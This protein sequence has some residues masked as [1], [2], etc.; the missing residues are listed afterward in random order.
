[1][2]TYVTGESVGSGLY[3]SWRERDLRIVTEP[4][5]VLEG[6]PEGIYRRIP[7]WMLVVLAPVLGGL[8]AMAF[9]AII[10]SALLRVVAEQVGGFRVHT[11]GEEAEWGVYV[12]LNHL[13]VSHV[14]A[15]GE[16]LGGEVGT[17]FLRVPTW[18]LVVGSP[19][20]GGIY[21]VFFPVI[22]AVALVAAVGGALLR[23]TRAPGESHEES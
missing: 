2:N 7:L 15:T 16:R 19:I 13:A 1:M 3:L 9:P 22:L 21:V 17:R 6:E 14:S 8:Y 23:A 4:E 12:A 5:Q 20:V 18:L 10:F 11:A